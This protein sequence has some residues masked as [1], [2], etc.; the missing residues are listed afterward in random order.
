MSVYNTARASLRWGVSPAAV[1]TI[2]S[3]FLKDLILAG[4]LSPDKSYLACDLS[5]LARARKDVIKESHDG[6]VTNKIVG[7][8]YDGRKDK[9]ARAMVFFTSKYLYLTNYI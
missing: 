2:A 8:G 3:E 5:K 1:A 6:I 4:H 7:M 9:N